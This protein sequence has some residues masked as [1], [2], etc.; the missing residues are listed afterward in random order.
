M[1]VTRFSSL[2]SPRVAP[3][4]FLL[5]AL[6]LTAPA[7]QAQLVLNGG[8]ETPVINGSLNTFGPGGEPAG[9][10]W[11]VLSGNIDH[12][13]SSYWQGNP[14]QSI[15][16]DGTTAATI[17]QNINTVAGQ[18]YLLSFALAGNPDGGIK[19][20]EVLWGGVSQGT[21]SFDT[22]GKSTANMGWVTNTL[23]LQAQATTTQL[24]FRSLTG[25]NAGPALDSVSLVTAAG[26]AAPEPGSIALLS[27][28]GIPVVG[29]VRRRKK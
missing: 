14:G 12:I 29:L 10:G 20:L 26:A 15:D 22:T 5:S 6:V 24:A 7:A 8:F 27:V 25:G 2:R 16:L 19:Q 17:G 13:S 9:F 1:T 28:T 11:S 4:L 3:T 23:T 21:F 18:S